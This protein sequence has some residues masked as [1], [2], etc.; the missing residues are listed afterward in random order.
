[1]ADPV[2]QRA[3]AKHAGA[4]PPDASL[5]PTPDPPAREVRQQRKTR[6]EPALAAPYKADDPYRE[7][8]ADATKAPHWALTLAD[9]KQQRDLLDN[10]ITAIEALY[11]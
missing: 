11:R 6:A 1:M 3:H 10:A 4:E 2:I 9:L 7:L 8:A 5:N